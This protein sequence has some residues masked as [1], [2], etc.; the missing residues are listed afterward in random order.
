MRRARLLAPLLALSL[1]ACAWWMAGRPSWSQLDRLIFSHGVHEGND[2]ECDTCHEGVEVAA[3]FERSYLPAE[4]ICLDCHE[5]EDNCSECHTRV[6]NH[7][8]RERLHRVGFSH[9]QHLEQEG[10][11]CQRCHGAVMEVGD[12]EPAHETCFE[13]HVHQEQYA[14]ASCLG[15]HPAMRQ[16][17][18]RAVAEFDHAGDWMARHGLQAR[19]QGAACAQ[20]HTETSCSDCHSQVAPSTTFRLYREE[21][22]RA[23]LHRGDYI[24][25]HGIEARVDGATCLRCHQNP[26]YCES[27]HQRNGV[28]ADGSASRIP[29]PPGWAVRGGGAFHGTDARVHIETCAACHDQGAASG[30]VRCHQVGGIGGNPHPPGWR[31]SRA[32]IAQNVVC[33]TCH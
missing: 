4:E 30:C 19:S 15:C 11:E 20:C 8:P 23:L 21:T 5:R 24:S 6:E 18:L 13:C 32:E 1:G 16:M 29:H 31:R 28:S 17:P 10:M 12:T 3:G 14:A 27:C 25:I 22:G 7:R 2:V 9:R 26:G 33:L